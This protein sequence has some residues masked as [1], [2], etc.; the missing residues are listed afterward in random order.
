M[1]NFEVERTTL[2]GEPVEEVF[3][4]VR[5][6]QSWPRWSPWLRAEPDCQLDFTPDG[7]AYSWDGEVVGSGEMKVIAEKKNHSID[8][9]LT[10][11]KPWKSTAQ[12]RFLFSPEGDRT[13]TAW[14]INGKL[15][16]FLFW[17]KGIIT[18]TIGMDY[19]RGLAMLKDL[20]QTGSVPSELEFQG[21]Q[22]FP[23]LSYVGI[24]TNCRIADIAEKMEADMNKLRKWVQDQHITPSGPPLSIY[25]K[26][27]LVQGTTSYTLGFPVEKIPG[28]LPE[29]FVSGK[30]PSCQT[31]QIQHTGPY[32]HLGNAWAAGMAHIRAKK[33]KPLR[34]IAPFEI[35]HNTP[36]ETPEKKLVTTV[37]FP[38][39]ES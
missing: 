17:M 22:S 21:S 18:S 8:Y 38:M 9:E 19:K 24:K 35:Y 23:G 16:F 3:A 37:Y 33:W 13:R 29:N 14:K 1:S 39:K 11:L 26:W 12:V 28:W 2:I 27:S 31:Q 25:H 6:F 20:L 4:T 10:F 5:D 34:S 30:I 36:A 7:S 15:P 32:R